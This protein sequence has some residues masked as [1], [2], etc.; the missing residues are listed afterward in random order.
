MN[1]L[2]TEFKPWLKKAIDNNSSKHGHNAHLGLPRDVP[3]AEQLLDNASHT[4]ASVSNQNNTTRLGF[5][6]NTYMN[7]IVNVDNFKTQGIGHIGFIPPYDGFGYPLQDVSK[8]DK[9]GF[10]KSSQE[11]F[12]SSETETGIE[13]PSNP[14]RDDLYNKVGVFHSQQEML[15]SS[16]YSVPEQQI[17]DH[18][19]KQT[20]LDYTT[21]RQELDQATAA[22]EYTDPVSNVGSSVIV[23][24]TLATFGSPSPWTWGQHDRIVAKTNSHE[25]QT[26]TE[27]WMPVKRTINPLSA[28]NNLINLLDENN[29][30]ETKES[31]PLK[32]ETVSSDEKERPRIY[33]VTV[34]G[35]TYD[36]KS[37][38][39]KDQFGMLSLLYLIK[40]NKNNLGGALLMDGLN[41]EDFPLYKSDRIFEV[42]CNPW[43]HISR[44]PQDIDRNLPSEYLTNAYIK[45]KLPSIKL[46][47]YSEDLLFYLFYVYGRDT[48]Q[49]AAACE[50]YQREWRYH[51]TEQIWLERIPGISP[52]TIMDT[53]EQGTYFYFD[54]VTWR[55]HPKQFRIEY[56]Q[57]E[58]KPLLFSN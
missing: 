50:L 15:T 8:Y 39:V 28:R 46:S 43:S 58:E 56:N 25:V 33:R 57:L 24:K 16:T 29:E 5:P 3:F 42:F 21:T 34:D 23:D 17:L 1:P 40:S 4:T 41:R 53:W 31:V 6:V 20:K 2:S 49:V 36:L 52:V 10:I 18:L 9:A 22:T 19:K 44:C 54:V 27:N 30:D 48:I 7:Q 37:G 45:Q 26:K 14:W 13:P 12:R 55:K 38:M 51:K 35:T 32:S 11:F 47:R